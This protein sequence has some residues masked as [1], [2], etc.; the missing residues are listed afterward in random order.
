[1]PPQ[2]NPRLSAADIDTLITWANAEAPSGVGCEEGS[3][4]P[5]GGI[6][7]VADDMIEDECEFVMELRAHGQSIAG[8]ETPYAVPQKS[9]HYECFYFRLPWNEPAHGLRFDPIVDDSRVLHHWLLYKTDSGNES[10]G[11][12]AGCGGV[13]EGSELVAGWAPGGEPLIMPEGVGMK[14]PEGPSGLFVLEVHYNNAAGHQDAL[15]RSGVKICA[16]TALR[17]ETAGMQ[18]LGTEN[19]FMLAP[20]Q[21]DRSGWC[22]PNLSQPVTILNSSPHMHRRGRHLKSIVHRQG[23]GTDT[24][25]DE[26]FDFD[27]QVIYETPMVI[28]P[29]D[30]IETTCTFEN[31]P[32]LAHFGPGTDHEMCY[33]FV[34]AYPYGALS[35]GGSL[36]QASNACLR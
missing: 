16:T 33:N 32:G 17:E 6:P 28:Y 36:T 26:P 23:G 34:V 11:F 20:G 35:T 13:H 31:E 21:H 7:E 12:H 8:D 22:R 19:L 18:W 5:A 29:G 25:I 14:L 30:R 9:D 2:P 1:M 24:L 3:L 27:H 15:D 10:D 4:P